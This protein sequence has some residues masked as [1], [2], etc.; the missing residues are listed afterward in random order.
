M[1]NDAIV[2]FTQV[3]SEKQYNQ[4]AITLYQRKFLKI[5]NRNNIWI[6]VEDKETGKSR[7]PLPT[8]STIRTQTVEGFLSFWKEAVS[9]KGINAYDNLCTLEFR[10]SNN[11]KQNVE[12]IKNRN[13]G[14][15]LENVGERIYYIRGLPVIVDQELLFKQII[16]KRVN[17]ELMLIDEEF[18]GMEEIYFNID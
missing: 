15:N 2:S 12:F 1:E 3:L 8:N 11:Y 14:I 6:I 4:E 5:E 7:Y 10:R 18:D 16:L 9:N 17:T 13:I